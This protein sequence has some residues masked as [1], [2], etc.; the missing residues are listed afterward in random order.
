M[1]NLNVTDVVNIIKIRGELKMNKSKLFRLTV[2][3]TVTILIFMACFLNGYADVKEF[4]WGTSSTGSSGHR[5]LVALTTLLDREM[6]NYNFTVLPTPGAVFTVKKYAMEEMDG[7]YGAD[8]A[9]YELS[10]NVD[11]F[12]GFSSQ[13]KRY[14]VQ[15]FWAYTL[16]VGLAI[17]ANNM[18]KFKGWRDL[19]GEKVFTGP[20]AWDVRAALERPLKVLNVGH[21]YVEIDLG[22]VSSSLGAGHISAIN[23]YTSGGGSTIS[24]W[25][26]ETELGTDIAILNPSEE[27]IELLKKAGIEVVDIQPD[28][29]ET[30]VHVD[31]IKGVPFFYGFHTG[32][33]VMPEEDVYQMLKVIEENA[34]ELAKQDPIYRQ[35]QENM[36]D[37]Q[38]RGIKATIDFVQVHPGLARYLREKGVW[39]SDWDDQIA[40]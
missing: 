23:A 2:L 4:R 34:A 30:D 28:V 25:L 14:P 24:P 39:N 29:F 8:V 12:E 32:P 37:I 27:E 19:S 22:M 17:H 40:K 7:L 26:M 3:T 38:L 9:F 6:E 11:R 21:K 33:E 10:G 31:V 1:K 13:I 15:S 36:V 16:E 18:E 35:I 20:A 5:A